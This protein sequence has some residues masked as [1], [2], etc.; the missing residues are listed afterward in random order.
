MARDGSEDTIWDVWSVPAVGGDPTMLVAGA[1][2]PAEL[3]NGEIAV[4]TPSEGMVAS[5]IAIANPATGSR[6]TLVRARGGIW[7]PALSPGGTRVAYQDG[8]A[9]YVVD[10]ATGETRSL[11][12]GHY[13]TWRDNRTLIV[14]EEPAS[15]TSRCCWLAGA[16][17]GWWTR[18]G[19]QL[20]R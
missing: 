20:H 9:I 13:A 16:P 19:S 5:S 10:V 15:F 1:T 4:A 11:G 2:F 12:S 8:G 17:R 6:R 3:P 18:A 14:L 7:M